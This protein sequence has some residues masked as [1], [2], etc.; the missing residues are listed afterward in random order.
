M[1]VDLARRL[2]AGPPGR[3]RLRHARADAAGARADEAARRALDGGRRVGSRHTLRERRS[4]APARSHRDGQGRRSA[5]AATTRR[6]PAAKDFEQ[7][8]EL[9][10]AI[11]VAE[12]AKVPVHIF[13]FKIRGKTNWGTIG[14]YIK[15]IE[16]ARGARPE[17]HR[18]SVSVHGDVPRLERVL[19]GV[20]ARGRTGEV[21]RAPEGSGARARG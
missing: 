7:K 17:H 9:D 12:E 20:D 14:R 19:P 3:P 15:Q 16:D 1:N 11:R 21:R 18:E 10:F 5:T 8:K 4:R 6:T 13:H 2:R